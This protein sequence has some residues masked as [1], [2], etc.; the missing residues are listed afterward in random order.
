[1]FDGLVKLL[2]LSSTIKQTSKGGALVVLFLFLFFAWRGCEAL[3]ILSIFECGV[4]ERVFFLVL[5]HPLSPPPASLLFGHWMC[6]LFTGVGL[7]W[8][9][10]KTKRDSRVARSNGNGSVVESVS[11]V[12]SS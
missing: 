10:K 5:F 6:F 1:M 8:K 4:C 3:V 11:D 9:E 12:S 2:Q 7:R